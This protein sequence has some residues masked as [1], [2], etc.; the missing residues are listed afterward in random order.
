M[1]PLP[2]VIFFLNI[3]RFAKSSSHCTTD[4]VVLSSFGI[5]PLLGGYAQVLGK[6]SS[7]IEPDTA[8]NSTTWQSR[9]THSINDADAR[10]SLVALIEASCDGNHFAVIMGWDD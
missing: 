2:D 3:R 9:V 5:V 6:D 10:R 4:L 1:S 8:I 7:Y